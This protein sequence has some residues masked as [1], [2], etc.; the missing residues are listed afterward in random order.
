MLF[1]REE[2]KEKKKSHTSV[3]NLNKEHRSTDLG[4]GSWS[5]ES[6]SACSSDRAD[7]SCS[8]SGSE[9][10]SLLSEERTSSIIKSTVGHM[11][12]HYSSWFLE[13]PCFG[14]FGN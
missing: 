3:G 12:S 10:K 2:R 13:N 14:A 5:M 9:D 6:S 8:S 4:F 1:I 11:V 7:A